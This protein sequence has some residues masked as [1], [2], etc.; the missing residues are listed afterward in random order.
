MPH[1]EDWMSEAG[2][3]FLA[4]AGIHLPVRLGLFGSTGS[5]KSALGNFLLDP[6]DA[7]IFEEQTFA[8]GESSESCTFECKVADSG[9]GVQ[10]IDTPGL[11]ESHD[12]DLAHVIDVVKSLRELQSMHM[13]VLVKRLDARLD[14]PWRDTVLFYQ[15]LCGEAFDNVIVV[16]TGFDRGQSRRQQAFGDQKAQKIAQ[17]ADESQALLQLKSR[18]QVFILDSMPETDEEFE[19]SLEVRRQI[20][21]HA[22]RCKPAKLSELTVPKTAPLRQQDDLEMGRLEGQI[23]ELEVRA[24]NLKVFAWSKTQAAANPDHTKAQADLQ[25]FL[26]EVHN[27]PEIQNPL[28]ELHATIHAKRAKVEAL[29]ATHMDL[30]EAVQRHQANEGSAS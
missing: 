30:E 25:K 5:G 28:D 10:I 16:L 22:V 8:T 9:S 3:Q 11:Q 23:Q 2:R 18:P 6:R 27:D 7:H 20:L 12:R 24:R 19:A 13:V 1:D 26:K 4:K 14:Q 17:T 29:R 21:R 15:E